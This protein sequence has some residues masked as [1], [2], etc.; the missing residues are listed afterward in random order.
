M[1]GKIKKVKKK[2]KK[3]EKACKGENKKVKTEMRGKLTKKLKSKGE[4]ER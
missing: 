3:R 1:K 2:R 4:K